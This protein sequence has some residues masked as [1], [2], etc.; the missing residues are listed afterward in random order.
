MK[1]WRKAFALFAIL[2]LEQVAQGWLHG[3]QTGALIIQARL[4]SNATRTC[5][6]CWGQWSDHQSQET[7]SQAST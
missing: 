6:S 7:L 3:P 4:C 5:F 1:G 2:D